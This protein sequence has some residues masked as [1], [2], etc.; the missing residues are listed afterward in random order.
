MP[1]CDVDDA[2]SPNG[3]PSTWE[4]AHWDYDTR[5]GYVHQLEGQWHTV[6]GTPLKKVG[7][8]YYED[9]TNPSNPDVPIDWDEPRNNPNLPLDNPDRNL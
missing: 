2:Q 9:E 6:T 3:D 1:Q 5:Y 7:D 4:D 8:A